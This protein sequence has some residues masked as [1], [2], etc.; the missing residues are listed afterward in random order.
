MAHRPRRIVVGVDGSPHS[1]RAV[2]AVARL[3]PA[4]GGSVTC[5]RVIELARLPSMPLVPAAFRTRIASGAAALERSRR[6]AAQRQ[7]D[8]AAAALRRAGWRA[9][10][11]VRVG[12][13]LPEL[14]AAV[15]AA[16]ADL[17][18][19]GA[20]GAGALRHF[21]LGGVADGALKRAPVSVL[22]AR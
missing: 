21:L 8:A 15:R 16:R 14:L 2:A 7:A 18:V 3:A 17:L 4:R 22:V 9:R 5:V 11:V 19:V 12:I 20:R 6:A 1:R 10:G 13:P